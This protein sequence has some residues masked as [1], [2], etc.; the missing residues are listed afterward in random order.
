MGLYN[1]GEI[2]KPIIYE[3]TANSET[4]VNYFKYIFRYTKRKMFIILDNAR[5]HHSKKLE[6]LFN[7]YGQKLMFL[8]PYSPDLNKI[9]KYWG[10]LKR[11]LGYYFN[12][13]HSLIKN[14]I[15]QTRAKF[16]GGLN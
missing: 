11:K 4:I 1:Q 6:E 7:K 16:I 5:I 10:S 3:N 15:E 12:R 8:P 2:Y 13:N 9:E 14:I